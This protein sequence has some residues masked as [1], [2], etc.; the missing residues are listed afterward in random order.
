MRQWLRA[1]PTIDRGGLPTF[2]PGGAPVDPGTLFTEWLADAAGSGVAMPHAGVLST[3]DAAGHVSGRTLILKDLSAQQ[4]YFATRASSPKGRDLAVN[5]RAALTFFWA[6][7]GRQVRLQ[8][9]VERASARISAEDFRA[10]P[11]GSRAAGMVGRQSRPLESLH[12]YREAYAQALARAEADPDWVEPDWA[13]YALRPDWVEFWQE[14]ADQGQIRLRYRSDPDGNW[15]R[16]LL[17]P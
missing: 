12:S 15:S 8:G 7:R 4:W 6:A 2:D 14:T 5:P 11:P 3:A 13:V 1:L 17:W 16:S 10:R 9:P